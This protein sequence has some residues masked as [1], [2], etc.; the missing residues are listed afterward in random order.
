MNISEKTLSTLEF[1]KIRAELATFCPTAG[2]AGLALSLC[3]SDRRE[4]I[5]HKQKFTTD[6]RRL[7][8]AKGMP[9]FGSVVEMANICERAQK[10]ATL[11]ARELLDVAAILRSA[12]SLLDYI[13]ANK[14]FDTSLD[15]IFERLLPNRTLE[16]RISRS[17]ISEELI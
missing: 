6:A 8:D 10:G 7:L 15:V 4:E 9:P 17:I 5:K 1:D 3:P 2:G 11:S 16:D 12:R 13:R 14:L